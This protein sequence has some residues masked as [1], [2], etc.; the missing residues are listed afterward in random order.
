MLQQDLEVAVSLEANSRIRVA[1]A[2][3]HSRSRIRFKEASETPRVALEAPR[4]QTRSL[5]EI[6]ML[7]LRVWEAG[8]ALA[9]LALAKAESVHSK[10]LV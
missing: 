3:V 9:T 6:K 5:V 1:W 2:S 8:L 7:R 10:Q 4:K